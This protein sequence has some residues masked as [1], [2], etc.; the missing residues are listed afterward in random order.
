MQEDREALLREHLP[1]MTAVAF[2]DLLGTVSATSASAIGSIPSLRQGN[3]IETIWQFLGDICQIDPC[4]RVSGG[5]DSLFLFRQDFRQ[6]LPLVVALFQISCLT[7]G[8]RIRGGIE[9]GNVYGLKEDV[10]RRLQAIRNM[11]IPPDLYGDGITGAVLAE[12]KLRGSRLVLGTTLAGQ[13]RQV[14]FDEVAHLLVEREEGIVEVNWTNSDYTRAVFE[15]LNALNQYSPPEET[16]RYGFG[17]Y[18]D[19]PTDDYSKVM[20]GLGVEWGILRLQP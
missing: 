14:R 18:A 13:L 17:R 4:L 3:A 16:L 8:F 6:L 20:I 10:A 7:R 9:I 2:V 19:D 15:R 12:R 5:S 1:T 11:T